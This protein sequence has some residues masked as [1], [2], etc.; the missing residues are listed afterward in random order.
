MLPLCVL[1]STSRL[2]APQG[3]WMRAREERR[4][5]GT[6]RRGEGETGR[7]RE[8]KRDAGRE[9]RDPEEE[10][11]QLRAPEAAAAAV[12]AAAAH[13][14][15]RGLTLQVRVLRLSAPVFKT[16]KP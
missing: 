11:L 5:R 6:G 10:G 2:T 3:L 4:G 9:G 16:P 8:E 7:V 13:H 12:A 15:S 1:M 14:T